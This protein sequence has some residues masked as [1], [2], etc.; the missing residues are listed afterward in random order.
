MENHHPTYVMNPETK[1]PIRVG[2]PGYNRLV[3]KGLLN[4]KY[5]PYNP[6]SKVLHVGKTRQDCVDW[7]EKMKAS[8]PPP[9][10]HIYS[11]DSTGK[12]SCVAFKESQSDEDRCHH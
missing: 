9:E 1:R 5:K 6:E 2:T 11:L 12:S 7:I 8:V 10:G 4:E 3:K